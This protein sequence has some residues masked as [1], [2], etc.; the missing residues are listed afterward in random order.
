MLFNNNQFTARLDDISSIL[1]SPT[2]QKHILSM[3]TTMNQWIYRINLTVDHTE[4]W[5]Q[6]IDSS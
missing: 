1:L 3:S 5:V 6:G 2:K 4:V